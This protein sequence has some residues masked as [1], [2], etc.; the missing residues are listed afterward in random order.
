MK[1]SIGCRQATKEISMCL[2][3]L[4]VPIIFNYVKPK[5]NLFTNSY[6]LNYSVLVGASPR[7]FPSLHFHC[8]FS[9]YQQFPLLHSE[10][11]RWIGVFT[12]G[13]VYFNFNFPISVLFT[14]IS[15]YQMQFST[16]ETLARNSARVS[17]IAGIRSMSFFFL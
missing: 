4:L 17:A 5:A 2:T 10:H 9:R 14:G 6:F 8:Q 11:S 7:N 16:K 15:T 13:F 1:Y 12:L 3:S